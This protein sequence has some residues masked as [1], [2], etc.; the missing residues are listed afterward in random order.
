M[1]SFVPLVS[2]TFSAAFFRRGESGEGVLG[3]VT[4]VT[5]YRESYWVSTSRAS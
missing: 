2:A 4:E 1:T 3:V 5:L